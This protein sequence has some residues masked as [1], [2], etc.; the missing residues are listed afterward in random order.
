MSVHK[1][2]SNPPAT[3]NP[4]VSR[5]ASL[6]QATAA[7]WDLF[8]SNRDAVGRLLASVSRSAGNR[9]CVLGAGNCNDIDLSRLLSRFA[10]IH[11]IDIDRDAVAAG[12][13]RQRAC[14]HARI[15]VHAPV[16]VTGIIDLLAA[17][18]VRSPG[19]HDIDA[20]I[21]RAIAFQGL[22]PGAGFDV[23][24]S[25]C[26]LTQLI[27]AVVTTLGGTHPRTFDLVLA[28]RARHLR[29]LVELLALGGTGLLVSDIVSSDTLPALLSA[30]D[31]DL[32]DLMRRAV[33][34]RNFFTGANPFAIGAAFQKDP[35]LAPHIE[36]VRLIRPWRWS[37]G[38][39]RAY[40]VSALTFKRK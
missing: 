19:D 40:L 32:W 34:A 1:D 8:A 6:N 39:E 11:L 20:G 24:L 35:A 36:D 38:A 15:H 21:R 37:I 14:G 12:V 16:D 30:A 18:R 9:L 2:Q 3:S 7:G 27:D 28:V 23:V 31:G 13:E 5:Q 17:W 25:T 29:L 33:E 4:I 10:E 22:G 26:I